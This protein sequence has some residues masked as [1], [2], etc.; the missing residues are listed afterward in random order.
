MRPSSGLSRW[1]RPG[2]LPRLGLFLRRTGLPTIPFP[3][4]ML[5]WRRAQPRR[6]PQSPA[7]ARSRRRTR[8]RR[9]TLRRQDPRRPRT[10]RLRSR[11]ETL[12]FLQ[13]GAA[14]WHESPLRTLSPSHTTTSF[15][16]SGPATGPWPASGWA[17][18]QKSLA[19]IPRNPRVH[20]A[21]RAPLGAFG[22]SVP[23][24]GRRVPAEC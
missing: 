2:L 22:N 12:P 14:S 1:L 15:S 24:L 18:K 21:S 16:K 11:S 4:S 23:Q 3:Q 19:R 13:T 5:V 7:G 17:Q 6:T 10:L 20:P 9:T 8:A